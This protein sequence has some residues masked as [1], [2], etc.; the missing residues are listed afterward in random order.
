MKN[1]KTENPGEVSDNVTEVNVNKTTKKIAAQHKE[2]AAN[3]IE[4]SNHHLNAAR[5]HEAGNEK[6]ALQS[7][8]LANGHHAIACELS[9]SINKQHVQA[10]KNRIIK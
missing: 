8:L 3:Y 6:K 9:N 2:A 4:A 10:A 1:T 5:H 7:S